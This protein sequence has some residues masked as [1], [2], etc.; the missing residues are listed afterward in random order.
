MNENTQHATEFTTAKGRTVRLGEHYRDA[1]RAEFRD[2]IVESIGVY[3]RPG[4]GIVESTTVCS[5]TCTVSRTTA[6]GTQQM[7]PT[8]M[9]AERLTGRDFELVTDEAPTRVDA[10]IFAPAA[11]AATA[12]DDAR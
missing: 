3:E 1:N 7:K 4:Y 10:T 5:V 2:L 11:T 8:T 6:A 12:K 9:T